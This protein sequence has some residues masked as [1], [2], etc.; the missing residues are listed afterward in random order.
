MKSIEIS[1]ITILTLYVNIGICKHVSNA[2]PIHP[3][4]KFSVAD[5][6]TRAF[7]PMFDIH[8]DVELMYARVKK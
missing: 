5:N 1:G 2:P 7:S 3:T 6:G 8:F 4:A